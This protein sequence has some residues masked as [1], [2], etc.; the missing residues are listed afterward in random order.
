VSAIA[1][2]F[3]ANSEAL[4]QGEAVIRLRSLLGP[5]RLTTIP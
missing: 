1:A 2:D 3:A 5:E 4:A